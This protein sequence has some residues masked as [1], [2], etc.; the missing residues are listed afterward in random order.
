MSWY[1]CYQSKMVLFLCFLFFHLL[2]R[3][4]G[5]IYL[6]AMLQALIIWLS[7]PD[8]VLFKFIMQDYF[9][10]NLHQKPTSSRLILW[11]SIV[12]KT[13]LWRSIVLKTISLWRNEVILESA[14][15]KYITVKKYIITNY[16]IC[17]KPI[18]KKFSC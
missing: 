8:F 5:T 13:M 7:L 10:D 18:R 17:N 15:W 9:L 2:K 16:F 11:R 14:T 6:D 12:L 1:Y 3:T 4:N